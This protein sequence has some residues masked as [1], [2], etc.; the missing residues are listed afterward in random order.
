[1]KENT[2]YS[3]EMDVLIQNDCHFSEKKKKKLGDGSQIVELMNIKHLL[4]SR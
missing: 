3:W 2:Q 4:F 1:M